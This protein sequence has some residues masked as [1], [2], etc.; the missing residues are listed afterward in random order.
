MRPH[1]HQVQLP[2]LKGELD[3]LDIDSKIWI[4]RLLNPANP[5]WKDLILYRFN[6]IYT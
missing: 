5:L 6:L 1:R 2:I 4:Q 3:I